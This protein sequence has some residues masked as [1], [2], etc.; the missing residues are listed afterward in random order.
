MVPVSGRGMAALIRSRS[1]PGKVDEQ[2]V[3]E[4][5]ISGG[6]LHSAFPPIKS[7]PEVA[8]L[9]TFLNLP[10]FRGKAM[11]PDGTG[12]RS[13]RGRGALGKW[14]GLWFRGILERAEEWPSG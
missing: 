6:D 8:G 5:E 10:G 11:L 13:A 4:Q 3:D 1:L 9:A 12:G 14:R 2:K 7:T